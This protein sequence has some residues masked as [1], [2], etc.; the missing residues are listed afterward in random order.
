MRD[1][2]LIWIF[3]IVSQFTFSQIRGV[4]KD[5]IS[6]EPIPFVNIWVE[7]ETVGTTSETNG[8][9]SLDIKDEKLLVFSALGYETK[10]I[11]SKSEIIL[12]KPKVFELKEV[13]V[14]NQ[15]KTKELEIGDAHKVHISQLSGNKPWI[16]AKLFNY[17]DKYKETP[18]VKKIVFYSN[19]DIKGAKIKIRIFGF[20]DSI[21]S[22]DLINEDIIVT[23]KGGMKKN[24]IDVSHYNIEFP[25][26]GLVIGLEWLIIEENKYFFTYKDTKTKQKVSLENYAPS[27]VINHSPDEISFTYSK[28][29]WYKHKRH[30]SNF[31]K[32]WNN[33][34]NTPA[35]NLILTN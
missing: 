13:M 9:F 32:E 21:P 24:T 30:S 19:S 10:K 7:N 4:V 28:G 14:L 11:S 2:R 27:L 5:S 20:N 1:K 31:K 15:K 29:K 18:F 23:V 6:G 25:K 16:Y 8:S 26:S 12:L 34:V 3:L 35:I 33:K 22:E 17:D